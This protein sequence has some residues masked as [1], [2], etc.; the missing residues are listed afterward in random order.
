MQTRVVV[1]GCSG[2]L[3]RPLNGPPVFS[4]ELLESCVWGT[5]SGCFFGFLHACLGFSVFESTVSYSLPI[6]FITST[7]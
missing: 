7:I 2:F 3:D 4:P 5:T 6:C 1:L